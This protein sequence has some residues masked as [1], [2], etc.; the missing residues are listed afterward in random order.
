MVDGGS[1]AE[2]THWKCVENKETGACCKAMTPGCLA[3]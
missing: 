3:C 2:P 1:M